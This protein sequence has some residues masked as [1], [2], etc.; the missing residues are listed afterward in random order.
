MEK[1]G[2]RSKDDRDHYAKFKQNAD[3]LLELEFVTDPY[4]TP[5]PTT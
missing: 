5:I 1:S 2:G 4:A 3:R